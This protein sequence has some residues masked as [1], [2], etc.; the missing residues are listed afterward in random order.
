MIESLLWPMGMMWPFVSNKKV[1]HNIIS[2]SDTKPKVLVVAGE[3]DTLVGVKIP[4]W[5][6]QRYASAA[7]TNLVLDTK[8]VEDAKNEVVSF[9]MTPKSGHNLMKDLYWK[10]SAE[11]IVKFLDEVE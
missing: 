2:K 11:R 7:G 8:K 5:T 1:L 4:R 3:K 9:H 10:D 6:A